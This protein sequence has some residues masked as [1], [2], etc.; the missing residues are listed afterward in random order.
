MAISAIGVF[1]FAALLVAGVLLMRLWL[2]EGGP[3]A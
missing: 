2:S 3:E 1:L